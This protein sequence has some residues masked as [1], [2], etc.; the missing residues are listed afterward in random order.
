MPH[1]TDDPV[2]QPSLPA[3]Q[4]ESALLWS[5]SEGQITNIGVFFLCALFCWLI[6]P[7]MYGLYR[8]CKTLCHTY[9]LT[10]Q[11]LRE[12]SGILSKDIEELELFRVK[13]ISIQQPLL[14][15][16]LGRG[17]IIL[18]TSDHTTSRVELRAISDPLVVADLLRTCVQR[19]RVANGV[20]EID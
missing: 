4:S 14:Q 9:S 15:R 2:G 18:L 19:C 12:S 17:S 3:L 7:V 11:R 8:F 1:L 6:F 10:D 13:D 16:M 20:R 5:G